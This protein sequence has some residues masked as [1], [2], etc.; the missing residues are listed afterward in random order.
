MVATARLIEEFLPRRLYAPLIS[1]LY[2]SVALG[3]T[4]ADSIPYGIQNEGN[5]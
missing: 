5:F 2:F 4:C 1:V 3:G